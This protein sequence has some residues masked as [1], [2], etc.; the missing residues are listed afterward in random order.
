[1]WKD[2]VVSL[3]IVGVMFYFALESNGGP[4]TE[5]GSEFAARW[6]YAEFRRVFVV[7]TVVWGMGFVLQAAI[8]ITIIEATSTNKA[9][10]IN[11]VLPYIFLAALGA[12]TFAYG[13]RAKRRGDAQ[14]QASRQ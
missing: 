1:M 2:L 9:F 5:R 14:S 8:N 11:K 3:G 6:R 12:W 13:A 7:M 4:D 10:V